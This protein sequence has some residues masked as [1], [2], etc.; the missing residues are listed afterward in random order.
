MNMWNEYEMNMYEYAVLGTRVCMIMR[1]I[2]WKKFISIREQIFNNMISN[3]MFDDVTASCSSI[4][5]HHVM[6]FD[7]LQSV[8][9]QYCNS[10]KVIN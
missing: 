5:E 9:L 4:I 1:R 2:F 6:M 7:D 8:C 3:N 10:I